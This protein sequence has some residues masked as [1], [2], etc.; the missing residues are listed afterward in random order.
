[1]QRHKQD[2]YYNTSDI[3]ED[4]GFLVRYGFKN[5]EKICWLKEDS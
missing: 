2:Y 5:G 3:I 1:M 4:R